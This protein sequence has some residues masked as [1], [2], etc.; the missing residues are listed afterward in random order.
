MQYA[1]TT[2]H[3]CC[4]RDSLLLLLLLLVSCTPVCVAQ[5]DSIGMGLVLV[6]LV[7]SFVARWS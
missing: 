7:R 2:G 5:V 3:V 1:I 6:G 4:I